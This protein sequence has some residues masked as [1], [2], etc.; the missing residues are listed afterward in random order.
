MSEIDWSNAPDGAEA[1]MPRSASMHA[2][3]Y[4]RDPSGMVE[5]ICPMAGVLS[6]TSMGGRMD[7]PVGSIGRPLASS[8]QW[9]GEGLPPVGAICEVRRV[10]GGRGKA[11]INYMSKTTCVW[12]WDNGNPDQREWAC[13][14]WNMEFRPALTAKQVEEA[15]RQRCIMRMQNDASC[16]SNRDIFEKPYDAGYRK[17]E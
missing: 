2:A 15:A 11:R 13:E 17:P 1:A 8:A 7:F 5:Q 12:L 3:W 4:R 6:W 10:D 14:P 9:L 16:H